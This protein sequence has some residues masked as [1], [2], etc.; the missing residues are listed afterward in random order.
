MARGVAVPRENHQPIGGETLQGDGCAHRV[1]VSHRQGR[2]QALVAD[3][4]G[5]E[6]V[7]GGGQAHDRNIEPL[8][9]HVRDQARRRAG[10]EHDLNA[11]GVLPT[12]I[13]IPRETFPGQGVGQVPD[14]QPHRGAVAGVASRCRATSAWCSTRRASSSSARAGVGERDAPLRAVEQPDPELLLELAD[15][16]ADG[17]L[18]HVQ[19]LGGPAEMEFLSDGDEIPQV[20]KFHGTMVPYGDALV[21]GPEAALLRPPYSRAVSTTPDVVQALP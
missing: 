14:P 12:M 5:A 10:L 18:R 9:T 6:P 16:L 13:C 11:R 19:A 7:S 8:S 15:L 3:R 17:G 4:D 20:A 1:R 21:I 2:H